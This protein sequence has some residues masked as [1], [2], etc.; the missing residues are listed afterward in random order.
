MRLAISAVVILVATISPAFGGEKETKV[1]VDLHAHRAEIR[2]FLLRR[3]PIG[4]TVNDV[5]M[6]V[7]AELKGSGAGSPKIHNGPATGPATKGSH[8]CGVTHLRVFLGQYYDH[9][10]IVFLTAPML[11]QKEVSAQWAFDGRKQ[12]IEIF[13]DKATEVY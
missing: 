5:L 7:T 11:M 8:L 1:A 4:S 12:L 3:T 13:V 2:Q 10:E 6:F 9:P